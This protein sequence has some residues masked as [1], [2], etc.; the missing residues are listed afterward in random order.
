MDLDESAARDRPGVSG[1]LSVQQHRGG[2]HRLRQSARPRRP[3]IERAAR[4]GR[5]RTNSFASCPTATTR[6]SANT[7]RTFRA[8]SGSGW[9][10]PGRCCSN[11]A[12][13]MLD[14]PTSAVD[15]ETE[16]EILAGASTRR[17]AGRTTFIVA[18]RL[19][20]LRRADRIVVLE[21]GRI[22]ETGTHAELLARPGHYRQRG[23]RAIGRRRGRCCLPAA[24]GRM[25]A[26]TGAPA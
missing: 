25:I 18:H 4:I 11:P 10:W 19:S 14:D 20:T 22:V 1:K 12:I 24:G 13:L 17:C 16:H 3:Q 15:P 5:G 23:P 26:R 7:A 21:A 9:R 2:E 6:W 8:A